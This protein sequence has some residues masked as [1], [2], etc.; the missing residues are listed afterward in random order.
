MR[1]EWRAHADAVVCSTERAVLYFG[2][3]PEEHPISE[4][5]EAPEVAGLGAVDALQCVA[6]ARSRASEAVLGVL[7]EDIWKHRLLPAANGATQLWI[8]DSYVAHE[9]ARE[10]GKGRSDSD[11]SPLTGASWLLRRAIDAG[12]KPLRVQLFTRLNPSEEHD[13]ESLRKAVRQLFHS[14]LLSQV[15]LLQVWDWAPWGAGPK[16]ATFMH[17]RVVR[18]GAHAVRLGNGTALFSGQRINVDEVCEPCRNETDTLF[19]KLEGNSTERMEWRRGDTE[20]SLARKTGS[21]FA[22]GQTLAVLDAQGNEC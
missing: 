20:W 14:D 4:D 16:P 17:Q 9:A 7:R 2:I 6:T 1:N 22:L 5:G 8:L 13:A 19:K 12:S 15:K 18:F 10:L 3:G 21:G 11:A